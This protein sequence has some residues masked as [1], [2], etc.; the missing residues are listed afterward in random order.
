LTALQSSNNYRSINFSKLIETIDSLVI[1]VSERFSDSSLPQVCLELKSI[2]LESESRV[3]MISQA[4]IP[5]RLCIAAL[6]IATLTILANSLT[7]VDLDYRTLTFLELTQLAETLANGIILLGVSL[8][9]LLS[10]EMRLKRA[11]ARSA[12]HE[13]RSMAHIIDLLQLTKDPIM[14]VCDAAR[15]THSPRRELTQ[16]EL[17]RYLDYCTEMLSLIGKLAA[18]YSERLPDAEIVTAA[19]EIEIL[20]ASMSRKIWQKMSMI[21]PD[22]QQLYN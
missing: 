13:L 11:K 19:N 14:H 7:L 1:R 6:I 4:I 20:C 2:A 16:F 12:L 5:I 8:F 3:A 22:R 10:I 9:F 18:I 21:I 15:T 17:N